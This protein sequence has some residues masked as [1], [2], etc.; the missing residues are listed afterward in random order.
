M[1]LEPA[2]LR[3]IRTGSG[4]DIAHAFNDF[5][6]AF[7][8]HT[9]A[10]ELTPVGGGIALYQPPIVRTIKVSDAGSMAAELLSTANQKI[11]TYTLSIPPLVFI[12]GFFTV[13]S[14]PVSKM[15]VYGVN[16]KPKDLDSLLF[17][18]PLLNAEFNGAVCL[19]DVSLPKNIDAAVVAIAQAV[20]AFWS[21][22]FNSTLSNAFEMYHSH[23]H[24]IFSS[25]DVWAEKTQ[26]NPNVAANKPF[27]KCNYAKFATLGGLLRRFRMR[28]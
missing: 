19:G 25:L 14:S 23:N 12:Y 4:S 26:K 3:M 22:S 9:I 11:R 27:E 2:V 15:F 24:D 28:S 21:K 8:E 17:R 1:A 5:T 20:D 10:V 7:P 18:P 16:E 13:A 6:D